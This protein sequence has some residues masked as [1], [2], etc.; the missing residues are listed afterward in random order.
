MGADLT[1]QLALRPRKGVSGNAALARAV[2]DHLSQ[3]VTD[4]T[5]LVFSVPAL[6]PLG[7]ATL[8][9]AFANSTS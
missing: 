4:E 8:S 5:P 3:L 1:A 6:L 2:F 7:V 9:A